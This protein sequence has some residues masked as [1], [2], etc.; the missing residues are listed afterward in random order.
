MKNS[1]SFR[2]GAYSLA[3]AGLVGAAI[4][5]PQTPAEALHG[6]SVSEER[7]LEAFT[8]IR[9]KGAIDLD[10]TAGK[11]Q[12]VTI[13]TDE[14]HMDEVVT[15]VKGDTLVIDMDDKNRRNF[16]NDVDVDVTIS[17]PTLE[18]I[19]VLGAVDGEISDLDSERLYIEIKGAGDLDLK[20]KCAELEL[21]IKG[22]GDIDAED[23]KCGNVHVD[24]KGA[25]SAS[26]YAI[27]EI[28][29]SVKG[30]GSISVYGKPKTVHKSVGGIGS[31]SI[32]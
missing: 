8:K 20:G 23:L 5:I 28:D 22:A 16:W 6:D 11:D 9:I 29:A 30:V 4:L 13:K 24:V 2:R 26:V 19:E 14:D 7:A 12:K 17:L 3:F 31:I 25:G 18:G 27:D 21:D 32:R 1:L 15:F 10:L